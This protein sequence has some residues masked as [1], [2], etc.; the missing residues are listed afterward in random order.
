MTLRIGDR[1]V[2]SR[3]PVRLRYNSAF[4][5]AFRFTCSFVFI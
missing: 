5:F 1:D 4:S 2:D 3:W